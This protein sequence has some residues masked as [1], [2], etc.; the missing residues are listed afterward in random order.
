M[1]HAMIDIEIMGTRPGSAIDSIGAVGSGRLRP[2]R[3]RQPRCPVS[4]DQARFC[5]EFPE[6]DGHKV[7]DTYTDYA[8]SEATGTAPAART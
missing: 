6:R 5:R 3:L 2:L 1:N 8:I 4:T 7:A